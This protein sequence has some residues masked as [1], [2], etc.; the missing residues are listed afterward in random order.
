V[1]SAFA[2][3]SSTLIATRIY[4]CHVNYSESWRHH[5]CVRIWHLD[6]LSRT[7]IPNITL[8]HTSPSE[9]SA[10]SSLSALGTASSPIVPRT[11]AL[12]GTSP[13]S[14]PA[15]RSAYSRTYPPPSLQ[16]KVESSL[17]LAPGF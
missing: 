8:P 16:I 15:A 10:H 2:S 17:L 6:V 7:R 4:G 13:S 1:G 11:T 12:P 5:G 9:T 14:T 3:I